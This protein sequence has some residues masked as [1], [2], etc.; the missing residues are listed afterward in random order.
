MNSFNQFS[1]HLWVLRTSLEVLCSQGMAN[2]DDDDSYDSYD[3]D[4]DDKKV[5]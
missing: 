5:S 2:D 1:N 3:D 4:N